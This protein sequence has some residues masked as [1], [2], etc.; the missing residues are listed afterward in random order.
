MKYS[1]LVP[2][3]LLLLILNPIQAWAD[4]N[5]SPSKATALISHISHPT[6]LQD[7]ATLS[8]AVVDPDTGQLM[9]VGEAGAS[10]VI[11]DDFVVALQV[12]YNG[13][14]PAVSI[15]PSSDINS[16]KVAYFGGIENTRPGYVLYEAD[17]LLKVYSLGMDNLTNQPVNS[18]VPGYQSELAL[19][20]ASIRP[21]GKPVW[22]RMWFEPA[23]MVS[24]NPSQPKDWRAI[25]LSDL[26]VVLKTEYVSIDGSPI[27]GKGSDP[28]A[29]QFVANFNANFAAY[30]AE[31][32]VFRD[33]V[34]IRRW[35]YLARWL[36]DENIPVAQEWLSREVQPVETP[37]TTPRISVYRDVGNYSLMLG[38]GVDFSQ[39]NAYPNSDA[40][41][42]TLADTLLD[43]PPAERSGTMTVEGKNYTVVVVPLYTTGSYPRTDSEGRRWA[44]AADDGRPLSVQDPEHG[45]T[46]FDAYDEKGRLLRKTLNYADNVVEFQPTNAGAARVVYH[47]QTVAQQDLA[48]LIAV[49]T[50]QAT[51]EAVT[52]QSVTYEQLSRENRLHQL[53]WQ[54]LPNVPGGELQV[55]PIRVGSTEVWMAVSESGVQLAVPSEDIVTHAGNGTKA[56]QVARGRS[57]VD[58]FS[59]FS[60]ALAST[61]DRQ[62]VYAFESN[63]TL[64]FQVGNGVVSKSDLTLERFDE[65]IAGEGFGS[66]LSS[67]L[68]PLLSLRNQTV[69]VFTGAGFPDTEEGREQKA[70]NRRRSDRITRALIR[71]GMDNVQADDEIDEAVNNLLLQEPLVDGV[72]NWNTEIRLDRESLSSDVEEADLIEQAAK[73]AGIPIQTDIAEAVTKPNLVLITARDDNAVQA[74]LLPELNAANNLQ[75]RYLILLVIGQEQSD[76]SYARVAIVE[77]GA[78]GV[79]VNEGLLDLVTVRRTVEALATLP[80]GSQ[81][82]RPSEGFIQAIRRAIEREDIE[83]TERESLEQFLR[84]VIPRVSQV[85]E[86][87]AA[88]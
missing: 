29:E 24:V 22:H 76:R 6:T 4:I 88:R 41:S 15:D 57:A 40:F 79:L 30:S 53:D 80:A 54:A 87:Q 11:E 64:Y 39:E 74:L 31:Q 45:V 51:T 46:N 86:I 67:V 60:T 17:R 65:L 37:N 2:V 70:D 3:V 84:S 56:V 83:D 85:P 16:M 33:L 62:I 71:L 9:L 59:R 81:G 55:S 50:N 36:R 82:I 78:S 63:G 10:T 20:S 47:T 1:R 35:L 52:G 13:D 34:Q 25:S 58:L 8:A 12:I 77:Y 42:S 66:D 5:P 69:V 43:L 23:E 44:F 75:D 61:R 14:F 7:I 38:G 28:A 49:Q 27:P 68:E 19:I 26:G 72:G 21:I 18:S 48:P 73:G 32:P